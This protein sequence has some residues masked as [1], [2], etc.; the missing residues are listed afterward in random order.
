MTAG[1]RAIVVFLLI[2]LVGCTD[3]E[4]TAAPRAPNAVATVAASPSTSTSAPPRRDP[5]RVS[6]VVDDYEIRP[7]AT[8]LAPGAYS[9]IVSNEDTAPHDVVL[10]DT[11][12]PL[13]GLPTSGIRVDEQDD[14]LSVGARTSRID[15]GGAGSLVATLRP[16]RYL[17]VCTVPHHYVRDL[18][19]VELTGA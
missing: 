19:A 18:M 10:I 11:D 9:F 17:L 6:V 2:Q 4:T 16:G 3:A 15:P 5:E 13:D 12:L 8:T 14:R 1:L 7:A